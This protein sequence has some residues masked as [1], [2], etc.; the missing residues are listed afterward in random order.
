L[1]QENN[2]SGR[3][4]KCL[5]Q[6]QVGLL[7]TVDQKYARVGSGQVGPISAVKQSELLLQYHDCKFFSLVI[8]TAELLLLL[9]F[10]PDVSRSCTWHVQE[11]RNVLVL[12]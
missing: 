10:Y 5:C 2:S 1:G 9:K 12:V 4:K 11:L 6:R 3:V 8:N 7:F